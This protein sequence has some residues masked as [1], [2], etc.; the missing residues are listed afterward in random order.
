MGVRMRT[1]RDAVVTFVVCGVFFLL[2]AYVKS[3]S[4]SSSYE[5]ELRAAAR[6][7]GTARQTTGPNHIDAIKAMYRAQGLTNPYEAVEMEIE[8]S[9]ESE[10][11]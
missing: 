9:D 10:V 7:Q 2:A 1:L 11:K 8:A 3:C 4:D 6:P 5:A